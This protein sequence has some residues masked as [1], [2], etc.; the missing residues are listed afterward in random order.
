MVVTCTSAV[1]LGWAG[2]GG[3]EPSSESTPASTTPDRPSLVASLRAPTHRPRAGAAWP[4][5]VTARTAAGRPLRATV[6]YAYL[7]GGAVVARR[8]HYRFRGVF[9]DTIRWPERSVG[10]PL[11][12]RA[13]VRTASGARNLD[14]EVEVR[15]R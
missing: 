8:S 9:H 15:P 5:T 3:E 1:L 2:C 7:Y 6:S 10:F 13:V 11:T 12:F 14:Y 4:I